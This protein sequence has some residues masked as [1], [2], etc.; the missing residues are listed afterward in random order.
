MKVAYQNVGKGLVVT[1]ELLTWGATEGM[2]VIMIGEMWEGKWDGKIHR[3][4]HPYYERMNVAEDGTVGGY[5]RKEIAKNTRLGGRGKGWCRISIGNVWVTGVYGRVE[6]KHTEEAAS[7]AS[8]LEDMGIG[9][10]AGTSLTLGDFNAHNN[11]WGTNVDRRGREL[12]DTMKKTGWDLVTRTASPSFR[13]VVEGTPRTSTIDLAWALPS[14]SSTGI[15][16]PGFLLSDHAV[17]EVEIKAETPLANPTWVMDW[18]KAELETRTVELM[19]DGDKDIWASLIPGETPYEKVK[20]L[21]ARWSKLI[22]RPEKA[23]KWFDAEVK[24]MGRAV[25]RLGRGGKGEGRSITD[26]AGLKAWKEAKC[27]YTRLIKRK[28]RECWDDF[29]EEQGNLEPWKVTKFS[30]GCWGQGEKMGDLID[31]AGRRAEGE[32]EKAALLTRSLF[33]TEEPAD[34][35][36]AW[37]TPPETKKTSMTLRR[38]LKGMS[39]KS[40]PGPD[41]IT[42]RLLKL[43][44]RTPLGEALTSQIAMEIGEGGRK[45]WLDSRVVLLPKPGG[46]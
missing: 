43:T 41:G 28:K 17:I 39:N 38:L 20:G 46:T 15:I 13:R 33:G 29:C 14:G 22:Q 7:M 3:Q 27:E 8:W 16:G 36:R 30:R 42:W 18:D 6:R 5:V 32:E 1:Q 26:S 40:A 12:A 31:E 2:D 34:P 9:R 24:K 21:V 11:R 10:G 4:S 45:E 19:G 23:K 37:T 35:P 25:R 44:M